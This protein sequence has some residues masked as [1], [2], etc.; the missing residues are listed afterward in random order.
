MTLEL[1]GFAAESFFAFLLCAELGFELADL[2]TQ[3]VGYGE[4]V[5]LVKLF[6]HVSLYLN[7]EVLL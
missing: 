5:L 1:V 3:G 4:L 7:I 6:G 2:G